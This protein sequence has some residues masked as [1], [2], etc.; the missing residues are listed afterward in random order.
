MPQREPEAR[1]KTE[2]KPALSSQLEVSAVLVI[3]GAAALVAAWSFDLFVLQ[4][5]V[6]ARIPDTSASTPIQA[7]FEPRPIAIAFLFPVLAGAFA[8]LARHMSDPAR[9]LLLTLG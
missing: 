2:P 1:R 9:T 4:T 3:F 8:L 7:V 6:L 5:D